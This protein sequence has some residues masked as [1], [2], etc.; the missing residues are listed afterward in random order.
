MQRFN[1]SHYTAALLTA[2]VLTGCGGSGND[3][4]A[5]ASFV[6]ADGQVTVVTAKPN[7]VNAY[8]AAR[9]LEQASWGPTPASVAEV[10]RLGIEGWINQQLGL[11][12]SVL[13]AP[14]YVIDYDD[15]NK[16]AQDLAWRWTDKSLYDLPLSGADQLRQRTTWALYNFIV[17]GQNGFALDRVE[18]FNA[19]Q[20]NSLGSFKELLR[21]VT[22]H[23]AMGNFLNNNQNLANSPNENYAR[24]LMQLFSIVLV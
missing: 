9:F 24:E 5:K 18:Y 7:N 3:V 6:P 4:P 17:F 21:V 8:A 1:F 19:L 16:A 12:A 2:W 14:N 20:S 15:S 23:P 13:N 10:Q 22:L 11:R